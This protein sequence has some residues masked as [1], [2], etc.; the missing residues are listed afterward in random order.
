MKRRIGKVLSLLTALAMV[1][2][3]SVSVFTDGI[4]SGDDALKIALKNAKLKKSQVKSIE[5]D[6]EKAENTYEVEFKYGGR[7]YE[8]EIDASTGE[9]YNSKIEADND[10]DADDRDD[11]DDDR[12]DDDDDDDRDDKDDRDDDDDD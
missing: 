4:G 8:Y 10:D 3:M 2:A 1:M 7:E 9:I 5:V 6:Y 12:D 11:D